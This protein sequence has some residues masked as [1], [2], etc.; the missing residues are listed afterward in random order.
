MATGCAERSLRR[1]RRRFSCELTFGCDALLQG[2]N[3]LTRPPNQFSRAPDRIAPVRPANAVFAE[4]FS[5]GV[6]IERIYGLTFKAIALLASELLRVDLSP[7]RALFDVDISMST[8]QGHDGERFEGTDS[9]IVQRAV[10]RAKEG[11]TA[12]VHFLYARYADDVLPYVASLVDDQGKAEEITQGLFA[13]LETTI[14]HC[15]AP[16]LPFA[17]LI[18]RLARQA[19]FEH[20]RLEE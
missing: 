9:Q 6:G 16:D 8:G 1:L 20:K 11:D 10:A 7:A 13:K 18:L 17:A 12:A 15:G 3:H 19:A 14:N 2:I 4:T 5:E